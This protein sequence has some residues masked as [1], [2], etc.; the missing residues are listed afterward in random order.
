MPST[1]GRDAT[2]V[3]SEAEAAMAAFEAAAAV[4]KAQQAEAALATEDR[5]SKHLKVWCAKWEADLERRPAD[6]KESGPGGCM[7]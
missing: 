2:A 5:I 3:D 4:L 7:D 1:S 6:V